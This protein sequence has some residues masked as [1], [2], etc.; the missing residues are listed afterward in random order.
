MV[1]KGPAPNSS[2][3]GAFKA[4]L[5]DPDDLGRVGHVERTIP[6]TARGSYDVGDVELDK[7]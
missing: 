2:R 6:A 5:R 4:Q 7:R 3:G 1:P